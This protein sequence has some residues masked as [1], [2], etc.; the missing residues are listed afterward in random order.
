MPSRIGPLRCS[1]V[2]EIAISLLQTQHAPVGGLVGAAIGKIVE[3]LLRNADDMVLH[4]FG[5]LARAVFGMLQAAL[6]L[7]DSP[8]ED[9]SEEHTSEL[10]SRENLVCRLL[11]EKKKKKNKYQ[12]A[13][14]DTG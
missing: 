13:K 2:P 4:E 3:R 1:L 9:R 6:P 10:Q 7:N 12:L 8:T 5:P 14:K 11:L